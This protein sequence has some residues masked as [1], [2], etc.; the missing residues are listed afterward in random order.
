[1]SF[2]SWLDKETTGRIVEIFRERGVDTDIYVAKELDPTEVVFVVGPVV[3]LPAVPLA[4]TLT[5]EL[6]RKVWVVPMSEAWE[7]QVELLTVHGG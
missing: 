7:N 6:G 3:E 1:M 2:P 5:T 4:E